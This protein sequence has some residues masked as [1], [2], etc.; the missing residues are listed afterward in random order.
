M[1]DDKIYF[2]DEPEDLN[3]MFMSPENATASQSKH[4]LKWKQSDIRKKINRFYNDCRKHNSLHPDES[5]PA[6]ELLAGLINGL[7]D[8][9]TYSAFL[10]FPDDMHEE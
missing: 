9:G 10:E 1:P 2:D 8:D 7:P 6:E 4:H 5:V 3:P